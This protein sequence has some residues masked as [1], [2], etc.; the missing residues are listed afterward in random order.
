MKK[1]VRDLLESANNAVMTH[2]VAR[3]MELMGDESIV[4]VDVRD[5]N[6]VD[7]HG[8]IP[9]AVHAPR[10]M[11]EFHIDPASPLHIEVFSSGRRLVFYCGSG[12]RS[13]LAAQTALDMGCEDVAHV[14]GGFGAWRDAGG[15]VEK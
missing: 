15:T 11:L 1:C 5:R 7:A 8:M 14:G 13:V 9:G 10:G 2:D 6:E 4:F 12:G 3:A